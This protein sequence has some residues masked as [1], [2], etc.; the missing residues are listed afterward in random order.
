[1]RQGS[2]EVLRTNDHRK[3]KKN[4]QTNCFV[5]KEEYYPYN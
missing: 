4:H 2:G 1:M 3:F 5:I